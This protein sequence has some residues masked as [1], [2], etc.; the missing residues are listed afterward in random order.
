MHVLIVDDDAAGRYLLESILRSA[1]Y[2]VSAAADGIEALEMAR[3]DRPEL[4]ISDIL[5]PRMDGYQLCREWKAD[6]GLADVPIAFYTASYTDTA[7]ERFAVDIGVDAFWRKPMDPHKL[8][9][10][11]EQLAKA[12]DRA[13]V[14]QPEI[15]DETD[16]L[17]QYNARLVDKLEE[18]AQSL[19]R[20]NEELRHAMELLAHEV[21]IKE[22]LITDLNTEMVELERAEAELRRERDFSRQVLVLADLFVCILDPQYRVMLF[23]EGAERITGYEASELEGVDAIDLFTPTDE[24]EEIRA[25]YTGMC[26]SDVVKR[27]LPIVTKSGE[28]RIIECAIACTSQVGSLEVVYNIFGVDITERL[29]LDQVKNDFIQTVSHELRTPLTSIIGFVEL[30]GQLPPDRIVEQA[31]VISDRLAQNSARMKQLVEELLEVNTMAAD[32][33]TLSL[34]SVDL[35]QIVSRSAEAVFRAPRH[36]LVVDV[37]SSM[38]HVVCDGDRMGRVVTNLVSNAVKYSPEGGEVRV[39]V[40]HEGGEAVITVSDQGVGIEPAQ[41]S[42]LFTQFTQGDMSSTRAFGGI[43]LG[44]FIVDQIVIA[45][46]GSIEVQSVVGEGSTFRVRVPLTQP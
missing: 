10:A 34:R 28:R 33:V 6:A 2:R 32:G 39:N 24:R 43:G 21:T 27:N 40:T 45:H 36:T 44:L 42:S 15:T 8:L 9:A 3:A 16:V 7:D 22:G 12:A 20:A 29:R 37:D 23:S 14:R 35:G 41:L 17:K 19:E 31:P 25:L 11:V 26:G 13:Q 18:K 38:P 30:L 5:M 46:R 1:D 4:L